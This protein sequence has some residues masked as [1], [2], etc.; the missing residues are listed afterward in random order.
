VNL[1]V[2]THA[3]LWW[4]DDPGQ[5][6][7]KARTAIAEGGNSVFVSAAAAW[8]IAISRAWADWTPRMTYR[9]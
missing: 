5:L 1:L 9:K 7:E 2:D 6:S 8:E 4:L 3:L